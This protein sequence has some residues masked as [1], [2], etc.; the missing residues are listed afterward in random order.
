MLLP[1]ALLSATL[2]TGCASVNMNQVLTDTQAQTHTFSQAQLALIQ[3]PEQQ[4]DALQRSAQLLQQPLSQHDAV[5]LSLLH[6]PAWQALLA[7]HWANNARTAQ[8][9][10]LAN[11]RFSI[12][13]MHSENEVEFGR[14]LSF[15]LLEL[16]TWPRR[17]QLAQHALFKQQLHLS[18]QVVAHITD[19]RQSWVRAVA[20]QQHLDYAKQVF[21]AAEAS[22]ILAQRMQATGN[23]N[24]LQR[25]Q[26]QL[27]YAD[28]ATQW[29]LAQH[30]HTAAKEHL[31][32]LL[33]L[34]SAQAQQLILPT[35]LPDLPA[36]PTAASVVADNAKTMRLDVQLAQQNLAYQ[37]RAQALEWVN[38]LTDV[39]LGLRADTSFNTEKHAT[40]SKQGVEL[41][42]RLPLFDAGDLQRDA[43]SAQRLAAT[44]QLEATVRHAASQL[45]ESYSAYRTA[46]DVAQH[47][48]DEI[49]PLRKSMSEE[50]LLRYNGM[51]IG[52]FD[53]LQ[54]SREQI[55]TV[56]AALRAHEQFW[57][58]D[59]AL[60]ATIMGQP[61]S[62]TLSG[63]ALPT[64]A[65]KH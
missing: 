40:H 45:R 34:T 9:G 57:L 48:R 36:A 30:A 20:A 10:R 63:A 28:A 7:Q 33:G 65:A 43:A 51:L 29:A 44:Q 24:K 16:L 2:L 42:L 21:E 59:A 17:H 32:R 64:E 6:S 11:P 46:Y 8:N 14:F 1:A 38:S 47:F 5:Q 25:A 15:G 62:S 56:M 3:S 22:Q 55:A 60:Q 52:V 39:E 50:N 27:F 49:V 37:D 12:E 31:V 4:S 18:S 54:D 19:V 23:F 58:A 41:E 26:Q 61:T 53:L 13:R 35:R